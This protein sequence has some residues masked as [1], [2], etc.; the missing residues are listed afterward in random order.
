MI[1]KYCHYEF[2]VPGDT[3]GLKVRCPNCT[4]TIN[5]EDKQIICPCPECGGM[6]DISMWMLGSVSSC[7]HCRK[8]IV[9]SL[10]DDSIKYLPES[11]KQTAMLKTASR[12]AGDIIG[13]YRVIR[14][15]GIG[16]MGEVYLVEHTLLNSRC[17]LKLLKKDA[18]ADDPET[19][20]R[21]LR[22]ARIASQ[23]QH[24]N[25]IAVMDAELETDSPVT[26]IVMEYVDGVSIEQVLIDGPMLEARALEI[27]AKVAEA[28]QAASEHKII[29]RD[30]KPAN[31]MLSRTGDVKL[32]DLGIAKVESDGKQNMT[33][34]MDNAVLG[35]PN[36]AAP[37]QLR[38]AH[39]VDCRA[40]IY[41]LGAT[42]FHML[43][44]EKPFD[45]DSVFGVMANVLEKEPPMAHTV[46]PDI[47]LKTSELIFR[48]MAKNR[49]DRPE[50]FRALLKELDVKKKKSFFNISLFQI[51]AKI[52]FLNKLAQRFGLAII[53]QV[54]LT[55]IALTV[56]GIAGKII[57]NKLQP[58]PVDAEI[59]EFT[60]GIEKDGVIYNQDLTRV[61]SSTQYVERIQI[62]DSVHSISNNA[63]NKAVDLKEAIL[64]R[65]LSSIGAFAFDG[66]DKL[67][68]L[69]I[70]TTVTE[71]GIGAFH[72]VK[73]VELAPGNRNFMLTPDGGLV[74]TRTKQLI[75][76]PP[77]AEEFTVPDHVTSIAPRCFD[78]CKV[79]TK[80]VIPEAV[81]E[82]KRNAFD[83]CSSLTEVILDARIKTIEPYLFRNCS[84]LME[85]TLPD[86]VSNIQQS[87]FENCTSLA[88]INIPQNVTWIGSHAFE[89]CPELLNIDLP[90]RFKSERQRIGLVPASEKNRTPETTVQN[91][92]QRKVKLRLSTDRK[93]LEECSSKDAV[94]VTVPKGIIN[95]RPRAFDGCKM[96]KN[97]VF[98]EGMLGLGSR[99]FENCTELVN[100]KLPS[101]LLN[102]GS[103]AFRNCSSMTEIIIP[104]GTKRINKNAFENCTKLQKI[105]IPASV[106]FLGE[107]VFKGCTDLK[108]I[109]L[110]EHL[111]QYKD[112]LG[113]APETVKS[114][115]KTPEN[116]SKE[117]SGS[118]S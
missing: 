5:I 75:Y 47:S 13:K 14:C 48:M 41:S 49:D 33:L 109:T 43:T 25:L 18:M 100:V 37:E 24:P 70:P 20:G 55:I 63:F 4:G 45:S 26:Y 118:D 15:L 52:P 40:D 27:I 6:L 101:T 94:S 99:A 8:E 64:P 19:H 46:N 62:P 107:D 21:L 92:D 88:S 86:S 77:T 103:R 28:L 110:P 117:A 9:L 32:A 29:H 91:N 61:I 76:V 10:G 59:E 82:I 98:P 84:S 74:D 95:V 3:L 68:V 39:D 35:T 1:C 73:K 44:G 16:G 7:P 114:S 80:A 12:K 11:T 81:I 96:L 115:G 105:V 72:G 79:L 2:Y 51:I 42:L 89:N 38:S 57:H 31:I 112:K 36:Y 83:N 17:A 93:I 53:W 23:I 102:I 67:A 113:I 50:N 54:M 97:A 106:K 90:E 108:N 69:S 22:E 66:C 116:S 58:P 56:L 85:L 78:K 60:G 104:N 34:T 30:I 65:Y 111:M 87:A 71:I